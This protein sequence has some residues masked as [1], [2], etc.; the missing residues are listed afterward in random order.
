MESTGPLNM[1]SV[2]LGGYAQSAADALLA[3]SSSASAA[4][5]LTAV[6]EPDHRRHADKITEL[7]GRG[8]K[9]FTKYEELLAEPIDA[10]WLPLPI[11]LHRSF[12]EKAFAAGKAVLCEK[13]AAGC[14]DDADAMIAA[15]DRAGKAGIIGFQRLYEPVATVVKQKLVQGEIGELRSASLLCC[16]PRGS[17]YYQRSDWAGK[18][19]RNGVW[20]MDSPA[21]NAISHYIHL[22]LFLL[23]PDLAHSG[24]PESVE[25]ELYRANPIENYDTASMR[26]HLAGG[27]TL[28]VLLTHACPLTV[29]PRIHIEGTRGS[30]SMASDGSIEIISN[31]RREVFQ[32]GRNACPD[33]IR[34][35]AALVRGAPASPVQSTFEMARSHLVAVNGASEASPVHAVAQQHVDVIPNHGN[36]SLVTLRG[37]QFAFETCVRDGRMLHESGQL[38]WT[39][40][41]GKRDLRGYN[42]FAG[43]VSH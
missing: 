23:G 24:V 19:K 28:L 17:D 7:R 11:D 34:Q 25:A 31:N 26:F 8:I 14:V 37:I 4:V 36:G 18:F 6:C 10:V 33:M 15:R 43:P 1:G 21:N 38:S 9:V 42:H 20:V 41:T 30:M 13:P 22:A 3:E 12:T 16:W 2:G 35:F 29:H 40:P 5:R 39:R 32:S 27:A